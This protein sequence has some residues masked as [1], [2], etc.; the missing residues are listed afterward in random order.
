MR[1]WN[2]ERWKCRG[3]CRIFNLAWLGY[4]PLIDAACGYC[5]L[6]LARAAQLHLQLHLSNPS[7]GKLSFCCLAPSMPLPLPSLL[8]RNPC[9]PSG[10]TV[11]LRVRLFTPPEHQ[12]TIYGHRLHAYNRFSMFCK[13]SV[14]GGSSHRCVRGVPAAARRTARSACCFTCKQARADRRYRCWT[15]AIAV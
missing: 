1:F 9:I 6:L 15:R 8:A 12:N 7:P 3:R 10:G 13:G 2:L 11:L 4:L 5:L 14:L